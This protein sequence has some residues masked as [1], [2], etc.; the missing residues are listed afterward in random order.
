MIILAR[1][2]GESK[3]EEVIDGITIKRVGFEKNSKYS[4]PLSLNPIWKKEIQNAINHYKPS[5]IIV[6]EIMLGTISGKLAKKHSIPI[7][8]DMAENYPAAIKLWKKYNSNFVKKYLFHNLDIA[9]KVERTSTK[10]M[11][12]FI[13]VCT[14]NKIRLEETLNYNVNSEIIYNTPPLEKN[15]INKILDNKIKMFHHGYLTNEKSILNFITS[16]SKLEISYSFDIYGDG[17]NIDDYKRFVDTNITDNNVKFYGK[18]YLNDLPTIIK[19]SNIGV[20][21]YDSNDFNNFTIHNKLFDFF[22]FG[23]PVISG[24]MLPTKKIVESTNSGWVIETGNSNQINKLLRSIHLDDLK[25]K[26]LNSYSAYLNKY[27]WSVDE[28]NLLQFI[29]R[30]I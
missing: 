21:P 8:M 18:Y 30:F 15:N 27:N 3:L 7:I 26:S 2:G 25:E 14:E 9:D 24:N 6:R 23:L 10:F 22:K 17:E 4:T 5:L 28:I 20:I 13:F 11:D 12:G 16:L 19:N 29:K 1:W